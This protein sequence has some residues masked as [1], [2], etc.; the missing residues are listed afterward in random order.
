NAPLARTNPLPDEESTGNPNVRFGMPAAADLKSRD[1]FLIERPQYVL[2]Y[3][4]EQRRPNWVCWRLRQEDIGKAA[5]SAFEPDPDLPAGIAKVKSSVYDDS[6]FDRGHM[7]PAKDRSNSPENIAATF[8]MTN[9]VPQAPHC[10]Q[11]AWERLED[12][13]RKLTRQGK[14][15]Y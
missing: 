8:F 13:C 7:C 9:I 14:V 4:A 15:L 1:A 11:R 6:G 10:N 5:R 2:S 3:N 12:Y